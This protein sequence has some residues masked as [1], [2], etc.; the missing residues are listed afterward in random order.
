MAVCDEYGRIALADDAKRMQ[1]SD[2]EAP[3]GVG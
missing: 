3:E 1:D 2:D